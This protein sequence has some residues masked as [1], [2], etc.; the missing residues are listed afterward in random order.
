MRRRKKLI[1]NYQR[2]YRRLIGYDQEDAAHKLHHQST[3]VI[4]RWEKGLA[5]PSAEN[6]L[7]LSRLYK[8][9]PQELYPELD[10][11]IIKDLY[12]DAP[13]TFKWK[14]KGSDP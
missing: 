1:R 7:K 11:A 10:K 6:L 8:V 13:E 9:L 12:P 2:K 5:M 14:R 4:S 3:A